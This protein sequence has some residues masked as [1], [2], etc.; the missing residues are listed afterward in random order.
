MLGVHI[1]GPRASDLIAEAVAIMT[2]GGSAGDMASCVHGH[3]SMSESVIGSGPGGVARNGVARVSYCHRHCRWPFSFG[4]RPTSAVSLAD[5]QEE[6]RHRGD[7][8]DF[9]S[10]KLI[11]PGARNRT[12]RIASIPAARGTSRNAPTKAVGSQALKTV[13][14]K[15]N[16]GH[17]V[18]RL[19]QQV[20]HVVGLAAPQQEQRREHHAQAVKGRQR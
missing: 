6:H 8:A 20:H 15:F 5:D 18:N 11:T 12:C 13:S 17:Q 2:Y 16:P 14:G 4:F 9:R 7:Q 3:P 1:L 10:S 19:L